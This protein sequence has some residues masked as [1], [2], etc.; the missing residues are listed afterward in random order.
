MKSY[1]C[2]D[3]NCIQNRARY[4]LFC[5]NASANSSCA[6]PLR[7]GGGGG[8][9][10][11]AFARMVSPGAWALAYPRATPGLLTHTWFLTRNANVADFIGKYQ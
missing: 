6:H 5:I 10:Y 9:N 2:Y 1:Q 3:L 11:G 7:G 4:I 8:G